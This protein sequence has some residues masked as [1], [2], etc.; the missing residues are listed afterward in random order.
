MILRE[1]NWYLFVRVVVSDCNVAQA[2]SEEEQG[3]ILAVAMNS[4]C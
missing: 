2:N 1:S 4:D 3:L